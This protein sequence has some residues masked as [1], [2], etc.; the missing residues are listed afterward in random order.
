MAQIHSTVN[1]TGID[2]TVKATGNR[3]CAV[4]RQAGIF[5]TDIRNH[6]D[7]ML[8]GHIK[9]VCRC[10]GVTQ[11][12]LNIKIGIGTFGVEAAAQIRLPDTGTGVYTNKISL[13]VHGGKR[14]RQRSKFFQHNSTFIRVSG[15]FYGALYRDRP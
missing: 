5:K 7:R 12:T 13:S 2:L 14:Q 11:I 15:G 1:S 3:A 10:I 8:N 9:S 6:R 4:F